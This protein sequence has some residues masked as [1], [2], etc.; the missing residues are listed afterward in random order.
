MSITT[1]YDV[2]ISYASEEREWVKE[3]VYQPLLR[4]RTNVEKHKPRI[5]FDVSD[6]GI[7]AGQNWQDALV[8]SL[9]NSRKIVLVYSNIYFDKPWCGWEMGQALKRDPTGSKAI[10]CPVLKDNDAKVT[11]PSSMSLIQYIP[12][13]EPDWFQRLC[14]SLSLIPGREE[15]TG[16]E[17]LIQPKDITVNHTLPAVNIRLTTSGKPLKGE[18]DEITISCAKSTLHGTTTVNTSDGVAVFSDLS[19]ADAADDV[20]FIASAKGRDSATSQPF[21]VAIPQ[22]LQPEPSG[23]T[24][25]SPRITSRG[26]VVFFPSGRSLAVISSSRTALYGIEGQPLPAAGSEVK[27]KG[28]RRLIQRAGSLIAIADWS[29]GI[30]VFTE[31]GSHRTWSCADEQAG[32]CT[33][34][35][36]LSVT[37]DE[38]YLGFWNGTV[39]R[40][41]VEDDNP[42]VIIRHDGGIQALAVTDDRIYVCGFDGMLCLYHDRRLA[43]SCQL[44]PCIRLLKRYPDCLIAIGARKMYHI[45]L[46]GLR[47]ME[48][49]MPL[50]RVTSVLGDID[51]PVVMDS[52]GKGFRID[53]DL[54]IKEWFHAA[55]GAVP[56]SADHAGYYCIL[57]NPDASRSLLMQGRIVFNY[58]GGTLAMTPSGDRFAL[59]DKRGIHLLTKAE[60]E[61]RIMA[62]SSSNRVPVTSTE[63]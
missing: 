5:F 2:F 39:Y 57:R 18:E 40:M 14:T 6:M 43:N 24:E 50:A 48:E 30:T 10:I 27:L 23:E 58:T 29:G 12:V 46:R 21:N 11:I 55:V 61:T 22:R 15:H 51:L 34:P 41:T 17:F 13:S 63:S 20:Q 59:G 9:V 62:V 26:D 60:F 33:I 37:G 36:D 38:V 35:G 42:E 44:E 52:S 31:T 19:L 47:V 49:T 3:H 45:E 53:S 25:E 32:G 7:Q 4:C 16:L 54:T 8:N 1:E 56:E 28:H